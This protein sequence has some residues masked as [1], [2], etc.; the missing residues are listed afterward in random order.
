MLEFRVWV[1]A[2]RVL[3]EELVSSLF[4]GPAD[5]GLSLGVAPGSDE[6]AARI[7]HVRTVSQAAGVPV[8][9]A[10]GSGD[11]ARGLVDTGFDYVV[12]SND[13]TLL[14]GALRDAVVAA[15]A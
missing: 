2:E 8:G 13:T 4:V 7:D 6:L 1:A 12:V 15:R 11:A 14:G 9:I 5:L 3:G 10:A